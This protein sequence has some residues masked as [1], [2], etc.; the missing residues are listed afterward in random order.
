M[1]T[2]GR[3]PSPAARK[4]VMDGARVEAFDLIA[5]GAMIFAMGTG[6]LAAGMRDS[7]RE[8]VG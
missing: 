6:P 1:Q 2:Y 7:A 4:L 3:R 8:R 5:C